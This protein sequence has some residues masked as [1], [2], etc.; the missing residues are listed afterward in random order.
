MI[1]IHNESLSPTTGRVMG[2]LLFVAGIAAAVALRAEWSEHV[3]D[4]RTTGWTTFLIIGGLLSVVAIVQ[5][6]RMVIAPRRSQVSL[7][8]SVLALGVVL[9]F[10]LGVGQIILSFVEPSPYWSLINGLALGLGGAVGAVQL[11]RR[12]R[13]GEPDPPRAE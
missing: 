3:G 1:Q 13:R 2:S 6:A 4:A 10:A 9:L 12:R 7:P 5:G 11:L 8:N